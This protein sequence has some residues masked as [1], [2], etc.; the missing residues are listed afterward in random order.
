MFIALINMS[1]CVTVNKELLA[2]ALE[3]RCRMNELKSFFF[4]LYNV[5]VELNKGIKAFLCSALLY[6]A[7]K[8]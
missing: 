3:V 8:F 4:F 7:L 5:G 6:T 1:S 2:G